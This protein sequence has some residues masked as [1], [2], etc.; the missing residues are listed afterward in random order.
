MW[1][2]FDRVLEFP[3]P[4]ADEIRQTIV[5]VLGSE[6]SSDLKSA[7]DH[8]SALM[9]GL[10]FADVVRHV[11]SARRQ[12]VVGEIPLGQALAETAAAVVRDA[13]LSRKL[14]LARALEAQGMSQRRIS[15]MTGLSRDTIRKHRGRVASDP[16]AKEARP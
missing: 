8:L 7:V 12:A 3:K 5:R 9:S 4:S 10:A 11:I 2:R 16:R 14:E 13:S 6:Y 1:R 15:E